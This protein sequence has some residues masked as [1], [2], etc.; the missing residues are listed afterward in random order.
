MDKKEISVLLVED[1][2]EDAMLIG[3]WLSRP[4][5][6]GTRFKLSTADRLQLGCQRLAQEP[7][8]VVLLDL[9]L[10]G[11]VG[12]EAFL[13]M[14]D[15][16]PATPIVVL[17]GLKDSSL[18]VRAVSLGAQ[19]YLV[20]G[21][22]DDRVLARSITHAIERARL[23]NQIQTLLAQDADGKLV[24][25]I[26][27]LVRYANVA[28]EAIFGRRA[29]DL[30]GQPF[31]YEVDAG[32]T[33]QIE[34]FD[35]ARVAEIRAADILWEGRPARLASVRD[36]T[37]LKRA[38]R[39]KAEVDEQVKTIERQSEFMASVSHELRNPLTTVKTAISS[40]KEGVA[41]PMTPKQLTFVELAE[42]NV[43]RQIKIITNILDLARLRSG[44]IQIQTRPLALPA[45]IHEAARW[46]PVRSGGPRIESECEEGLPEV[47]AD[48]DLL[49]QVLCNLID[50]GLRY[51]RARVL[52]RARS[53]GG[54]EVLLSVIDDG[55]GISEHRLPELFNRFVQ[56]A[57]P[58]SGAYK[59]TGLGLAICK[60]IIEGHGGAIWTESA[61]GKGSQFHCRIPAVKSEAR[62]VARQTNVTSSL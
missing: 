53:T 30:V 17:T 36:V 1:D 45:L 46:F 61:V 14:R 27:G 59:G 5:E 26:E 51:A 31:P 7:F 43:D 25:D 55:P 52:V 24:I 56:L 47:M 13:K 28:A 49:G 60:E 48:P 57:R 12:I 37:E 2:P 10:P 38:E 11:G 19:D 58:K 42:R 50:N 21:T 23:L 15:A 33:A 34:L 9:I 35:G 16:R 40:L 6:G 3:H 22:I 18:A 41:G 62:D 4:S 8:D 20:K 32:R 44:R 29:K 54:G 39:L